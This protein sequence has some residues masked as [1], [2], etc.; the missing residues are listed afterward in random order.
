MPAQTPQLIYESGGW[1][2]DLTRRELRVGGKPVAI[3]GRAFEIVETL[4]RSAG[5]LVTKD[6]L[7]DRV[8]HG[9]IVEENT[10]QVH[11]WALRRRWAGIAGC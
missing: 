8:W 5:Q 2:I 4:V 9:A 1:E 10:L 7:M 3:G 11:I 6:E